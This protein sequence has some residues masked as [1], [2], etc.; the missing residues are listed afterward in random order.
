[1]SMCMMIVC[2]D[3]DS[4]RRPEQ[5]HMLNKLCGVLSTEI[6]TDFCDV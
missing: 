5:E 4:N 3:D 1:M 2:L 6:Y